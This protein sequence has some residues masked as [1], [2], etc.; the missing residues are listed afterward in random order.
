MPTASFAYASTSNVKTRL[1]ITGTTEDVVLGRIC[2]QVN[3]WIE[4]ETGRI[5]AP[6][7]YSA[8]LFD[9]NDALENGRLLMIPRGIRTVSLLRVALY[10]GASFN[11]IPSTDYFLSPNSQER[12][13]AWPAFELWM[14]DIPSATNAAPYFAPGF[15]NIELTGTGGWA[16]APDEVVDVAETMVVRAY[17]NRATGQTDLLGADEMGRAVI[18]R[19]IPATFRR[20]LAR[21]AIKTVE[22]V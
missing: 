18:S 2:D 11:T 22:I 12:D 17:Q 10:T 13:P 20:V 19:S 3:G 6:I 15:A 1:G 7:T 9:G 5:I 16:A 14:T 21:Y 8:A 4:S